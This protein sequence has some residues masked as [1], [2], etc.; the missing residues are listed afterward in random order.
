MS[1]DSNLKIKTGIS[2][3][4]QQANLNASLNVLGDGEN[5]LAVSIELELPD[6]MQDVGE[7]EV[8]R[9]LRE[10]FKPLADIG[11]HIEIQI[12]PNE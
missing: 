5:D 12:G 1:L 4:S 11:Y 6:H 7:E 9:M 2:G 8:A 10:D 3:D